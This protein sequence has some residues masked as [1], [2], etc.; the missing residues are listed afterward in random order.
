M[1]TG[2]EAEEI[3]FVVCDVSS[4]REKLQV[5]FAIWEQIFHLNHKNGQNQLYSIDQKQR[6][7]GNNAQLYFSATQTNFL[8]PLCEPVLPL[9]AILIL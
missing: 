8:L 6:K 3:S 2:H 1:N 5:N 4:D 7:N 9:C